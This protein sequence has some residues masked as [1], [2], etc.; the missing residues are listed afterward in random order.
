MT[1]RTASARLA[2]VPVLASVAPARDRSYWRGPSDSG[3][4]EA[5]G[6]PTD[7]TRTRHVKAAMGLPGAGGS[8]PI[9][10][11]DRIVLTCADSVAE[12]L[13]AAFCMG[14]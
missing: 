2:T 9:V 12:R 3:S 1:L 14:K 11:G 10:V 13:V 8:T 5:T 7:F 4:A 6:L